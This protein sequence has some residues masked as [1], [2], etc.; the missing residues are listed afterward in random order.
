MN[1]IIERARCISTVAIAVIRALMKERNSTMT[2][3]TVTEHRQDIERRFLVDQLISEGYD[4]EDAVEL[5][6]IVIS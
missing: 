3:P 5:A 2:I 6:E 1:K 4:R